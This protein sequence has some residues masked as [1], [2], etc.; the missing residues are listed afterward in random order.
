MLG[1]QICVWVCA[2]AYRQLV[3]SFKKRDVQIGDLLRVKY[4]V[5]E[6][7]DARIYVYNAQGAF[8]TEASIFHGQIVA[9]DYQLVFFFCFVTLLW[10][11]STYRVSSCAHAFDSIIWIAPWEDTSI[12]KQLKVITL[13]LHLWVRIICFF[14]LFIMQETIFLYWGF[15]ISPSMPNDI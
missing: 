8:W 3:Y 14:F 7:I 5:Y 12:R 1:L 13:L 2:W 11:N 4:H 9:T 10:F 6:Y 15:E